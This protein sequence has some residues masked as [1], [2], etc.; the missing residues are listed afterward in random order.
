ME[1]TGAHNG[2]S[3]PARFQV[4]IHGRGGQGVVTAAE[5]LSVAA[6]A[7]GSWAQ[8]FPTFGSE[9][10]GAPVTAFCRIGA[11]PIRTREPV[12]DPD[13]L[14]VQDPTLL[15]LAETFAGVRADTYV[16]VNSA[17][18]VAALGLGRIAPQLRPDRC[19]TI[20]ATEL[21][22]AHT[23]R[24][25]PNVV[26]LG[27]FAAVTSTVSLDGLLSAVAQR[28]SGDVARSNAEAATEGYRSMRPRRQELVGAPPD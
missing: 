21:A 14:V 24:P 10:T 26:L 13:A 12:V 27:A 18:D 15:R 3:S 6:F 7:D 19:F 5:L 4:R 25:V 23:G 8:A 9:R 16:L 28:F 2:V 1:P 20:A 17:R 22:M 11:V